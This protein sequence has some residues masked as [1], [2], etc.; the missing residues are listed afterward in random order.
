MS[1]PNNWLDSTLVGVVVGGDD[2]DPAPDQS[3]NMR[4]IIPGLHGKDVKASDMAFSTM[5]KSPTKSSQSTFE[6]VLDPGSIVFVRKDT[7]SNQC[8]IVGTGNEIPDGDARVPG[9]I[10]LLSFVK[11][12]T[13][14]DPRKVELKIRI[15]PQIQETTENG[16]K[17]RKIQEKNK[18]HKHE[19]LN[20]LPANGAIAPLA[21]LKL[22]DIT[23]ISTAVQSFN[24]DLAN[25]ITPNVLGQLPGLN[26]PLGGMLGSLL[27]GT[28]AGGLQSVINGALQNINGS[29]SQSQKNLSQATSTGIAMDIDAARTA[30]TAA[31]AA[32]ASVT[33][34]T[35]DVLREL[36]KE[37]FSKM[38]REMQAAM[39]SANVLMQSIEQDSGSL[40]TGR[41]D[42]LTYL[43]N[44]TKVLSQVKSIGD[45]SSAMNQLQNDTTLFGQNKLGSTT[46][47]VPTPFGI[48]LPIKIDAGGSISSLAPAALTQAIGAFGSLMSSA[49]GFPGVNPGQNLFGGSAKTMLDMFG[50]MGGSSNQVAIQ[51][52]KVLNQS[53]IAKKFDAITKQTVGG[54]NPFTKMFS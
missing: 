49:S 2:N 10:D 47:S 34:L 1:L 48:N 32:Q 35:D 53:D 8:Q 7:G 21:G 29:L 12:F 31:L 38:P 20:G 5:M 24:L 26:I 43:Q 30:Q 23:G 19:L 50:R 4:V 36:A 44:S 17:I 27:T 46:I 41:C 39:K 33:A 18:R 28:L 14:K 37:L 16:V 9:N 54:G 22:P 40:S 45:M 25:I 13:G 6:G 15:P 42:P 3:C 11:H 52:S 51:L